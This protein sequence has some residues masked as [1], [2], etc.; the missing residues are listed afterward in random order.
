MHLIQLK[1]PPAFNRERDR[2]RDRERNRE[3][4]SIVGMTLPLYMTNCRSSLTAHRFPKNRQ[5]LFLSSEIGVIP[6]QCSVSSTVP[7]SNHQ[8][9]NS[10]KY[11]QHHLST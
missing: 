11:V 4:D 8:T 10:Q 2:D 5:E 7:K 9:F 3:R 6:E 1:E